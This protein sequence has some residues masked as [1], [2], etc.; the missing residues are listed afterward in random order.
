[1]I[2]CSSTQHVG[3]YCNRQGRFQSAA[4]MQ[5]VRRQPQKEEAKNG[6]DLQQQESQGNQAAGCKAYLHQPN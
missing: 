4:D 6:A 5:A 1:M 3:N 2:A